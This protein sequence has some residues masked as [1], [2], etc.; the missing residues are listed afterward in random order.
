MATMSPGR[1]AAEAV[2]EVVLHSR[3]EV[4]RSVFD[5]SLDCTSVNL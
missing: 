1:I 4:E 2:W 3:H 5:P